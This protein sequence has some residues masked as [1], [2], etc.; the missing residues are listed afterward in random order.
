VINRK[1]VLRKA[2]KISSANLLLDFFLEIYDY[3][4]LFTL[5][6]VKSNPFFREMHF[7]KTQHV[8]LLRLCS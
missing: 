4:L 2:K 3:M 5:R 6:I 7:C 8:L 1:N